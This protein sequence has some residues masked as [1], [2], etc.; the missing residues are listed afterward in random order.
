MT[1]PTPERIEAALALAEEVER[2]TDGGRL[3]PNRGESGHILSRAGAYR[4]TAPKLRTRAEVDAELLL[5]ATRFFE[6]PTHLGRET[7]AR[8]R[9][10]EL[11][12]APT[13]PE[14]PPI[15]RRA[16]ETRFNAVLREANPYTPREPTREDLNAES[17]RVASQR[18]F[19]KTM[20]DGDKQANARPPHGP[21]CD[22]C[23]DHTQ[24]LGLAVIPEKKLWL[25]Q[26]C[27]TERGLKSE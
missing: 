3:W 25:C 12:T 8:K 9:W 22:Y 20:A 26:R 7:E 17:V 27:L 19:Q 21:D 2:V 14:P 15:D 11:S 4:A 16:I 24:P 6:G 5:V 1:K 10:T 18:F 23:Q 13:A